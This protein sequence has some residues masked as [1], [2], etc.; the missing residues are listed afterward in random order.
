MAR[1]QFEGYRFKTMQ[2]KELLSLSPVDNPGASCGT[3]SVSP[4]AIHTVSTGRGGAVHPQQSPIDPVEL[5]RTVGYVPAVTIF[6]LRQAYHDSL[7]NMRGWL[8]DT[9]VSGQ[10]T[11]LDRL[12]IIDAWQQEMIEYFNKNGYCFACNKRLPRCG[13]PAEI[14]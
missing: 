1:G 8:L 9:T 11:V 2:I 6:Q 7:S 4:P 10:L 13:C 12:S 3:V 5:C 14:N